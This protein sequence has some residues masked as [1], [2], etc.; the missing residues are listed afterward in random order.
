MPFFPQCFVLKNDCLVQLLVSAFI[1]GA[2]PSTGQ[3]LASV[4]L[5]LPEIGFWLSGLIGGKEGLDTIVD[6]AKIFIAAPKLDGIPLDLEILIFIE[7]IAIVHMIGVVCFGEDVLDHGSG[8]D[9]SLA[10]SIVLQGQEV[11]IVVVVAG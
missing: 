7:N 4:V 6:F 11:V 1:A 8:V 10:H 3:V 9:Q 5:G 2:A